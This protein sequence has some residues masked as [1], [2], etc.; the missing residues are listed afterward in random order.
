[1]KFHRSLVAQLEGSNQ[2]LARSNV[3]SNVYR[4]EEASVDPRQYGLN[5]FGCILVETCCFPEALGCLN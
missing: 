5:I 3:I 2:L 4:I 1:M